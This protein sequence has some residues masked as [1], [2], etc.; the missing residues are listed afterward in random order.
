MSQ[1]PSEI[2][3]SLDGSLDRCRLGSVEN[4]ENYRLWIFDVA[5][6]RR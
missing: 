4:A 5:N 1:H 3:F 6:L 2:A